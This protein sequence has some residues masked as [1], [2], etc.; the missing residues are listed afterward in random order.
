MMYPPSLSPRSPFSLDGMYRF[1]EYLSLAKELRA[2][3]V[4]K[5][6]EKDVGRQC[7][8][9]IYQ[10]EEDWMWVQRCMYSILAAYINFAYE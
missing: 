2:V 8:S 4:G 3:C 9:F 1:D 10:T 6:T 5:Y 7:H